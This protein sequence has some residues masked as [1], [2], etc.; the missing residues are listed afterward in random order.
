MN[1]HTFNRRID[2]EYY[3]WQKLESSIINQPRY[4]KKITNMNPTI[5]MN[6]YSNKNQLKTINFWKVKP[7]IDSDPV[8]YPPYFDL[9]ETG[10]GSINYKTFFKNLSGK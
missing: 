7:H 8:W 10:Y 3:A 5:I 9:H 2:N 1:Q 6:E 4:I